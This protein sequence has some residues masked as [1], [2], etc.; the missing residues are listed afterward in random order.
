V[1]VFNNTRLVRRVEALQEEIQV[2]ATISSLVS[3]SFTNWLAPRHF[4]SA[5]AAAESVAPSSNW[6][7][8]WISG[9]P[10]Q[11]K[12]PDPLQQAKLEIAA[13]Q[14]ISF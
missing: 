14:V 9:S 6:Q 10:S 8:S 2:H 1:L 12:Q 13:L 7:W 4:F 11:P 5:Q 3:F